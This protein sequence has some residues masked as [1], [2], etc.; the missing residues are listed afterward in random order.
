MPLPKFIP[1]PD[2]IDVELNLYTEVFKLESLHWGY[3]KDIKEL[4]LNN[5]RKA[6]DAYTTKLLDLVPKGVKSVLDVGAGIGDNAIKFAQ[7]GYLVKALTPEPS[8]IQIFKELSKKY[9]NISYIQSKYEDLDINE[10]FDL[11]LMSESS[12]YFP[13]NKGMKQTARYLKKGGY[14]LLAGLF[15]KKHTTVFS[16]WNVI[17]DFEKQAKKEGL[18]L[19]KKEDISDPAAPSMQ[20]GYDFYKKYGEPAVNILTDY[21]KKA[22]KWKAAIISLFFRKELKIMKYILN[23]D[24]PNR[25]DVTKFKKYGRYLIY[26]Y[27]RR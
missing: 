23:K 8:Q 4:S 2:G 14:L 7:Q 18:N 21:Y 15:R 26:L 11:I 3:W 5:L 22:F 10:R 12:N 16:I 24:L 9:K 13:L 27:Q 25:L 6:Q 1:R 20:L 19:L 17:S